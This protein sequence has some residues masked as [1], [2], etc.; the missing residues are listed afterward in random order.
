MCVSQRFYRTEKTSGGNLLQKS[1]SKGDMNSILYG[2]L[3]MVEYKVQ[4]TAYSQK[5]HNFTH[6]YY[7]NFCEMPKFSL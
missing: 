2:K 7:A 6:A 4:I 5:F 1:M 3:R